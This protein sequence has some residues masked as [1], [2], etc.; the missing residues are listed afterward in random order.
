MAFTFS[1]EISSEPA[2]LKSLACNLLVEILV[3]LGSIFV[4]GV[5]EVPVVLL[6]KDCDFMQHAFELL[7]L[8]LA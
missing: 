5:N 4:Y 3:D 8:K 6:G 2:Y 7:E 1:S